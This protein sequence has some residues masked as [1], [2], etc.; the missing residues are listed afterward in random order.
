MD[1]ELQR[2]LDSGREQKPSELGT[3]IYNKNL[4]LK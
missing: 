4:L 1:C 2:D 3:K